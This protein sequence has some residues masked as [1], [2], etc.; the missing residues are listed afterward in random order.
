[1]CD[2]TLRNA[3]KEQRLSSFTRVKKFALSQKNIKD[4]FRFA[5]MHKDWTVSDWEQV[6]F[7]DE[8]KIHRFNLDGR[9]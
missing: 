4:N 7:S 3:L 6:V 2:N 9:T 1:M 8:T 5:Q